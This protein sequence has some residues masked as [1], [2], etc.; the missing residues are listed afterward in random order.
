[1]TIKA[2]ELREL[3]EALIAAAD[4]ADPGASRGGP[5]A[6]RRARTPEPKGD[7]EPLDDDDSIPF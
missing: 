4:D 1:M 7:L 3:G 6:E 5:V 2:K